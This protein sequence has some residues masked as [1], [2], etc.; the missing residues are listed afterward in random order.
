VVVVVAAISI[1]KLL[2]HVQSVLNILRARV[3]LN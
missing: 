3:D 2:G 1:F